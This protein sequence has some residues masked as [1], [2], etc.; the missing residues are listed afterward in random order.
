[1]DTRQFL[2]KILVSAAATSTLLSGSLSYADDTEIFFGGATV[3]NGI[4]P[5]VL[6]ILDDSGSMNW[7]LDS[8]G[9][10]ASDVCKTGDTR[11]KTMKDTF[12]SLMSNTNGIN[13]GVMALNQQTNSSRILSPVQYIGSAV[14]TKLSSPALLDSADDATRQTTGTTSTNIDDKTLVMGYVKNDPATT[15]TRDLSNTSAYSNANSMYYIKGNYACSTMAAGTTDNCEGSKTSLNARSTNSTST[16]SARRDGLF[17]FRNLNIPAGVTVTSAKLVITTTTDTTKRKFNISVVSSKTPDAFNDG[18]IITGTTF[19]AAAAPIESVKAASPSLEHSLD[20]TTLVTSL[21]ALSPSSNPISDIAI[22]LRSSEDSAFTYNV[23]DT[24]ASPRLE[25]TYSGS[26]N[27]ARTTGLRF[28]TVSIPRNATI[29]SARIDFVP[30]GSDNRTVVYD[31]TAENTGDA[32]AFASTEDFT[33]RTKS[34][35]KSWNALEWRTQNPPVYV[36]G[37]DVRSQ[38]QE[39]V[40]SSNWCGNNAMAFFLTPTSGTGSRVAHSVDAGSGLQPVLK[41][42]YSGGEEGCIN[43]IMELSVIDPKDDGRQYR[44]ITTSGGKKPTTTTTDTVN[45]TETAATLDNASD[46]Y[47][48]S[49]LATR[50]QKVPVVPGATVMDASVIV[51]PNSA[52]G[53]TAQVKVHFEQTSNSATLVAGNNT[54]ISGRTRSTGTNC[55]ITSKG[56]GIPVTAACTGTGVATELQNIF[57]T[58]NNWA[59][60]NSLTLIIS[61]TATSSLSLRTYDNAPSDAVKLKVK[62]ANGGMGTRGYLVRDY[63]SD[64]VSSM[65][66]SGNTPI[67]PTLDEAARYYTQLPSKHISAS[68]SPITSACQANYLVLLTDGQANANTDAARADIANLTGTSC[69]AGD[70]SGER[71]GRELATWMATTT[72]S[73]FDDKNYISMST[74]GFALQANA[75]AKKFL[76]DLARNGKGTSYNTNTASGLSQAFTELVQRA[77]ATN[78]TFVNT[79]APVNSFNRADNLDQLYF[80]LF[81]PSENDRWLGNLKRYRLKTEGDVATI[82]DADNAAAIDATTGFFRSNARSFWGTSQDGANIDAGGAANK[83]PA[84]GSRH[85]Y[86]FIGTNTNGTATALQALSSAN[87]RIT[88]AVLG[89]SNM[90]D[91]EYQNQLSYIR[92]LDSDNLTARKQMGDPIHSAPRLVTYACRQDGFEDGTCID[93]DISAIMGTNEGFVHAIS[94]SDGVEQFAFMPEALLPN[95][96]LLKDNLKSTSLKPRRYGMDNTVA[97]W[98]NDAN[99]NG[100]IYGDPTAETTEGLNDGEFV[101]AYATM[102][103]GGRNIYALDITDRDAPK[104]LWQIIGGTT[105]GFERLGQTWSMPVKTRIQVGSTVR[106]VLV[107]AGGYDPDQDSLNSAASVR[108]ADDMGNAIYIVDARTG[109]KIWS[110]SNNNSLGS[111]DL[112]LSKMTYSMPSTVRVI[113][114]QQNAAGSLVADSQRLADQIFVGDMGGQVWRLYINNGQSGAGL[115]TAGGTDADGVFASIGGT[116]AASA[117]RFYHEPDVA[118]L[119]INGSRSLTVNIGSGYRGHPLND[120]IEDRFYSFRTANLFHTSNEGTL[121]ESN[122]YDATQ[123]LVQAGTADQKAAANSAFALTSGGWYIRLTRPGEKVLSRALTIGGVLYFNTY[124]PSTSTTSCSAS[125][126]TNRSY[127]ARLLDA[128]PASVAANGNGTADDRSDL[129]N[130]GGIAGDPQLFCSG[131]NC[132]VLPDPSLDP[133][134]AKMPPLGKTY[135]MDGTPL[136]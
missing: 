110:A 116:T 25:I 109:E 69:A 2:R 105:P 76:E 82:V 117:R 61:Q 125:V 120:Y 30:A 23:G 96:K 119:N 4:R 68:P 13:V 52:S 53:T 37:P 113:D 122:L 42:A 126:G 70:D 64:L 1:M 94:T 29:T 19:L 7:C 128:T 84:P 93:P 95:I 57:N 85:L 71:C 15:I 98:V 20:V 111:Y 50:F 91:T 44:T 8:D 14:N 9:R 83:L 35:A 56:P 100:V 38:V 34:A 48:N 99:G 118:L 101:Y 24:T 108:T 28:Q 60:G 127:S 31:V 81:R 36:A 72:Q 135:W 97:L 40:N 132:W 86:T 18:T 77:L 102:G 26:E 54:N 32:T 63:V 5:N 107:F 73:E 136:N 67:V 90:S 89:D 22:R 88:K 79:S 17:L 10:S 3:D 49:F 106:D 75:T 65:S 123:N 21:K 66:A 41:V 103:R 27:N 133:V 12:R 80:A 114:I 92:G 39:L 134:N 58:S 33:L 131:D 112:T 87:T 104:I 59:D 62:L 43:P 124:E 51:T 11:M 115:V 47:T 78:T 130:S 129:S 74:I 16:P 121:T 6:F 55:T 45:I 46:T